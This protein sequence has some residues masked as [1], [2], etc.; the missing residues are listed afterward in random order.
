MHFFKLVRSKYF[1]K[2][3]IYLG[4]Q[5]KKMKSDKKLGFKNFVNYLNTWLFNE[6]AIFNPGFYK[7]YDFIVWKFRHQH[8]LFGAHK[9]GSKEYA[10]GGYMPL[11]R[12]CSILKQFKHKYLEEHEEH[13]YNNNLNRR[14]STTVQREN[15]LSNLMD[16]FNNKPYF[17]QLESVVETAFKIGNIE[18]LVSKSDS[19]ITEKTVNYNKK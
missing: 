11:S 9:L 17:E 16:A 1:R 13:V 10:A 19:L 3:Q 12:I 2:K 6:D 15:I 14:R 5:V 8:E 7:F 4:E 18:K